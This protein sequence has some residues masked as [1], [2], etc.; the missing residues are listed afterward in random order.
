V[1]LACNTATGELL[2][3]K[4]LQRSSLAAHG[5]AAERVLDHMLLRQ[6]PHV[7]R[8]EEVSQSLS[9][10]YCIAPC[11]RALN[12]PLAGPLAAW[13]RS[14]VITLDMCCTTGLF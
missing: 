6:H 13:A 14:T 8:L 12:T 9:E 10:F 5:L 4:L 1:L 11:Q 7:V 2:A 3:L